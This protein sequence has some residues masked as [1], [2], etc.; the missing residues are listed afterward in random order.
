MNLIETVGSPPYWLR[1]LST[2]NR[3]MPHTLETAPSGRAKC[4]ACNGKIDRETLRFGERHPNAFGDGEMTLW[5]HPMCA[6]YRRPEPFLEAATASARDDLGPLV[7]AAEFSLAHRRLP[8]LTGAERAPTGRARCR[9]CK[10]PIAKDAW[11]LGI[12]F[13]EEFRFQPGGFVHAVCAPTYFETTELIDRI[14]HFSPALDEA[15]LTQIGAVLRNAPAAPE[16][17]RVTP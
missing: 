14:R 16:A 11:R 5:F 3:A 6:A 7:A 1:R 2:Y 17:T 4:R 13:F 8:R 15:A 9:S 12:A 10:E